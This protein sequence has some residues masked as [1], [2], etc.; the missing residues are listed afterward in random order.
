MGLNLAGTV[1]RAFAN[2]TLATL[3]SVFASPDSRS[4]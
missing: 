4:R 1:S 2:V 3:D